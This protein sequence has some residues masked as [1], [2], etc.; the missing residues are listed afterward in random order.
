MK[1]NQEP[2]IDQSLADEYAKWF[3]AL[4]DG[5]RIRIVSLLARQSAPMKVGDIVKAVDISQSTVSHHLKILAQ[6]GFLIA[7]PRA[8]AVYYR[9]NS[10]CVTAFPTAA[11]VI[12]ARP[13][14]TP[15]GGTTDAC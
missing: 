15:A 2:A 8:T 6:V 7:E 12:M 13:P 10:A 9:I 5:T 14:T 3:K 1:E 4:A 11:D